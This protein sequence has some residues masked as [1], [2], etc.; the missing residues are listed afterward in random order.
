LFLFTDNDG[1]TLWHVAA[2][3]VTLEIF[4]KLWIWAIDRLTKRR[5]I[6]SN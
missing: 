6:I 5:E 2:K 1:R 4:L 3:E